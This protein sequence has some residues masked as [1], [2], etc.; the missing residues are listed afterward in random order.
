MH[1]RFLG[2][3]GVVLFGTFGM[4]SGVARAHQD[5]IP[6][7]MISEDTL[8]EDW[9]TEVMPSEDMNPAYTEIRCR[10]P[11]SNACVAAC[12]EISAYC[13]HYVLHPYRVEGGMGSLYWCKG[14]SRPTYT[15]SYRFANG[16]HCH[17][18]KP[19][20]IPYCVY[21]GGK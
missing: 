12:A 15:C 20:S 21:E 3:I 6:E 10:E 14:G 17:Y 13:S 16:E 18:L 2:L 11:A 5:V 19:L 7:D 1:K 9:V 8:S 4:L